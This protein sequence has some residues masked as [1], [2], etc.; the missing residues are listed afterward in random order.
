MFEKRSRYYMIKYIFLI[1][2]LLI[3]TNAIYAAIFQNVKFIRCYDGDTCTFTIDGIPKVFG[4]KISV[5]ILGID[6][7]EIRGKCESEKLKARAAKKFINAFM[8]NG[9]HISLVNIERGKYFRLLADIE[10]D[11]VSVS[12]LMVKNGHA[13]EYDGGKRLGWC[14]L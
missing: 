3:S 5:R 11:G 4:E 7:P 10:V 2:Y 12:E 1:T 13:R 8:H 14:Q 6:T 9:Q